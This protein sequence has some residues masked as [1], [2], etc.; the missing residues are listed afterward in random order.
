[1]DYTLSSELHEEYCRLIGEKINLSLTYIREYNNSYTKLSNES[2]NKLQNEFNKY[3]KSYNIYKKILNYILFNNNKIKYDNA[4]YII[5]LLNERFEE[6]IAYIF[7]LF[8]DFNVAS[9]MKLDYK[10]SIN[11]NNKFLDDN[12]YYHY[13][14]YIKGFNVD[15]ISNFLINNNIYTPITFDE[16]YNKVKIIDCSKEDYA[17]YAGINN[18]EDIMIPIIKDELSALINIHELVHKALLLKKNSINDNQIIDGETIPI[19]YEMLFQKQNKFCK[20]KLHQNSLACKLLNIY[21]NEPFDEQIIKLKRL[22]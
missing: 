6:I 5:D 18:N 22:I 10:F 4:I 1:M 15:N 9:N 19:F 7:N 8:E 16:V 20:E 13:I 12:D 11:N 17:I 2:R 14:N 3:I 21:K